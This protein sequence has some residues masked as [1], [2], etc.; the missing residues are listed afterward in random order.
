MSALPLEAKYLL[1]ALELNT[2]YS[3]VICVEAV[4]LLPLLMCQ[5]DNTMV[6]ERRG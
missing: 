5:S 2:T 4:I 1:D 6:D 3:R